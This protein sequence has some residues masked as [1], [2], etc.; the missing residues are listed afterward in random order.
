MNVSQSNKL[1]KAC[2]KNEKYP[3]L[4]PSEQKSQRYST[5]SGSKME[6]K[7]TQSTKS[8]VEDDLELLLGTNNNELNSTH[9][10]NQAGS[11]VC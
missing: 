1:S 8:D 10:G 5:D 2:K 7:N 11:Q 4:K 9:T 3:T 6:K